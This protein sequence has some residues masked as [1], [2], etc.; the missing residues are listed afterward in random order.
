MLMHND[1]LVQGIQ[2]IRV[3]LLG[4]LQEFPDQGYF[5]PPPFL[6]K[7]K[8]KDLTKKNMK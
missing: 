5:R 2:S 1:N 8:W 3:P 7:T 4:Q 6:Y